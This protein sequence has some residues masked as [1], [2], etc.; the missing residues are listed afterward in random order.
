M[1]MKLGDMYRVEEFTFFDLYPPAVNG[2]DWYYD[3][4]KKTIFASSDEV[5]KWK[6]VPEIG[7]KIAI[8][9]LRSANEIVD[10]YINGKNVFR[11][12]PGYFSE[13]DNVSQL[14]KSNSGFYTRNKGWDD[15]QLKVYRPIVNEGYYFDQ[16]RS[17]YNLSIH[18]L[19]F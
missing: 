14:H 16:Y 5:K 2:I 1:K 10:V 7:D 3:E 4:N 6:K 18:N 8:V 12:H 11:L 13:M 17:T 19:P 9:C 15:G